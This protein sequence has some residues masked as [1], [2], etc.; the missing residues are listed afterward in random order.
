MARRR[1]SWRQRPLASFHANVETTVRRDAAA[2]AAPE[3]E[4]PS[5][6]NAGVGAAAVNA[7]L[8]L[9]GAAAA[10]AVRARLGVAHRVLEM[11]TSGLL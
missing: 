11:T 4:K 2:N 7:A 10:Q 8:V 9:G 5:K 6:S 3:K 1:H